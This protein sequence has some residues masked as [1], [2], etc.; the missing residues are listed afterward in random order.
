MEVGKYKCKTGGNSKFIL[1]LF[2]SSRNFFEHDHVTIQAK[3]S[4]S[5]QSRIA[6]DQL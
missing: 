5:T 2:S 6:V 3:L 4:S 1:L